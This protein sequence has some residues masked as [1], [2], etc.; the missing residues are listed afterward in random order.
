MLLAFLPKNEKGQIRV[1]TLFG[2]LVNA[3]TCVWACLRYDAPTCRRSSSS[4]TACG[5]S[6]RSASRTT[7]ASTASSA[8]LVL[9]T[10]ILGPLVVLASWSFISERVKEFHLALLV[11]QTAMLG[12]L[13][14]HG[15]RCSSTSSSRR[16]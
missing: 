12:A 4:S 1:V 7:W 13:C 15:H 3:A 9:L 11:L 14:S 5:G 6:T 10:G 16:C 2:M 8:A